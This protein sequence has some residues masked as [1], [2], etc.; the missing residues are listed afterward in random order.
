MIEGLEARLNAAIAVEAVENLNSSYGYYIDESAWDA[1]ADTFAIT[2]GAKE[3]MDNG[4]YV[5]QDR[6]RKALNM[7]GPQGDAAQRSSPFISS[8]SLSSISRMRE[9]RESALRLFQLGGSANGSSGSWI[10]GIYENTAVKENGEWKFGVQ[11]LY[12]IFNALTAMA[13]RKCLR[14]ERQRRPRG[15][16]D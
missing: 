11:D 12:H 9:E 10:G 5:G 4:V 1:M 15:L 7:R 16:L 8:H 2:G 14:R 6:I 3:L 13:G